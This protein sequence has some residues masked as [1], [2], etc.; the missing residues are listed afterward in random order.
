QAAKG[1]LEPAEVSLEQVAIRS[2]DRMRVVIPQLAHKAGDFD[3]PSGVRPAVQPNVIGR[4]A[5]AQ[6]RRI[7]Q[8]V[9]Q[10]QLP[11][12]HCRHFVVEGWL[13]K[14]PKT[15]GLDVGD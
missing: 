11:R 4:E 9:D 2:G 3:S 10:F 6:R 5:R 14:V 15:S 1:E 7:R 12:N 8:L 13:A